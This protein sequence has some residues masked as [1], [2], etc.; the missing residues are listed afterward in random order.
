MMCSTDGCERTEKY[1][2]DLC[3]TCKYGKCQ[4]GNVA[5]GPQGCQTCAGSRSGYG[6]CTTEGCNTHADSP[7]GVCVNHSGYFSTPRG[8]V[9][10]IKKSARHAWTLDRDWV[11]ALIQKPCIYCGAKGDPFVGLDR[12]DTALPYEEENVVPCCWPCNKMKAA[13]SPDDYVA[14]CLRVAQQDAVLS[15]LVAPPER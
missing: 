8:K 4:C 11:A 13:M 1:T 14:H 9:A 10:Q 2:G 6:I 3:T 15:G 5:S 7:R 12:M